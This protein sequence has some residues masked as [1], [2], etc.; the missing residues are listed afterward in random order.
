MPK[1][2]RRQWYCVMLQ[3]LATQIDA[4]IPFPNPH[5]VLAVRSKIARIRNA[6][7][8]DRCSLGFNCLDFNSYTQLASE[9]PNWAECY[10]NLHGCSV[11]PDI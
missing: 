10:L 11:F 7:D 1:T 5:S 9:C 4:T 3:D 8:F 2:T 6:L